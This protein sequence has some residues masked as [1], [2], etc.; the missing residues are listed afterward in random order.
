MKKFMMKKASDLSVGDSFLFIA[1]YTAVYLA[2][3]GA[4]MKWEEIAQ[5]V[6]NAWGKIKDFF[7]KL[8]R[9]IIG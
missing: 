4:I 5:L 2:I 7:M 9:K 3:M 1:I 6:R 8:K